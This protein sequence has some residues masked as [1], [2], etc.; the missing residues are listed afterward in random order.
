[1][2]LLWVERH[3]KKVIDVVESPDQSQALVRVRPYLMDGRGQ[4]QRGLHHFTDSLALP[5]GAA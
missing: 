3:A 2:N 1:M 4:V 5:V